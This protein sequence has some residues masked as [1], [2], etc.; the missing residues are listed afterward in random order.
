VSFPDPIA[1]GID[2]DGIKYLSLP[3]LIELKLAS[4]MTDQGRM[5]DLSDVI[6][7]MKLLNLSREFAAEL[8]TFVQPKYLELWSQSR[9]RFVTLWRNKSLTAQAKSINDMI[10]SLQEAASLLAAMQADGVTLDPEGGTADDYACLVTMDAE[11]AKKYDMHEE[12]EFWGEDEVEEDHP[13]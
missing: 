12:T 2:H 6:E 5:K 13:H 1:A 4:G 3:R 8:D 9:R 7:L 11:I 10:A